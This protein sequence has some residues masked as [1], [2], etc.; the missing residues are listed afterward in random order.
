[1]CDL[2]QARP[3]MAACCGILAYSQPAFECCGG[4]LL[5]KRPTERCCND[6]VFNSRESACCEGR[7][8][9]RDSRCGHMPP[10]ANLRFLGLNETAGGED[11]EGMIIDIIN[12]DMSVTPRFS[13]LKLCAATESDG[14]RM[15]RDVP[16]LCWSSSRANVAIVEQCFLGNLEEN[17]GLNLEQVIELRR[18]ILMMTGQGE[19]EVS[20]GGENDESR[21]GETEESRGGETEESRGGETEENKNSSGNVR[22]KAGKKKKDDR[23]QRMQQNRGAKVEDIAEKA[24]Q[25]MGGGTGGAVLVH[26][27]TNNADMEGTSAIIGKGAAVLA[28]EFVRVVDEGT[29]NIVDALLL[30][31]DGTGVDPS[32]KMAAKMSLATAQC[33][34]EHSYFVLSPLAL[35]SMVY[36]MPAFTTFV[37]VIRVDSGLCFADLLQWT[38]QCASRTTSAGKRHCTFTEHEKINVNAPVMN[39]RFCEAAANQAAANQAAANQ[40]GCLHGASVT[41]NSEVLLVHRSRQIVTCCLFIGHDQ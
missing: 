24:G 18:M 34:V 33:Q 26:V 8:V 6:K 29:A 20:R 28:C 38:C 41:P 17:T 13:Q 12:N 1:M 30:K 31:H 3:R 9:P 23:R 32:A 35:Q 4:R 27:G 2:L 11:V 14:R 5:A 36:N 15:N 25:V 19:T 40:Y 7:V 22:E 16:E 37:D 10:Q 21:G 39:F